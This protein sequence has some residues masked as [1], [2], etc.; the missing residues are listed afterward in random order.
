MKIKSGFS[1]QLKRKILNTSYIDSIDV[2]CIVLSVV[3]VNMLIIC[4]LK[5]FSRAVASHGT[6]TAEVRLNYV[7][8]VY[9]IKIYLITH[10]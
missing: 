2:Q 6:S 8:Y 10:K 7:T 4:L 5:S 9:R 1:F 3:V